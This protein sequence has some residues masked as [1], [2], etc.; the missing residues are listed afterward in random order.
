[1][2]PPSRRLPQLVGAFLALLGVILGAFAAHF[3][4]PQLLANGT[5]DAF[6]TGLYYQWFHA[7]ALLALGAAGAVRRGPIVCWTL[8][9][10][11][12]SG[13]LYLLSLDPSLH[14][15]GPV[16]PLG[17]LM[18]IVGWVWFIVQLLRQ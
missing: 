4:K 5:W 9:V 3:L 7:L 2:S 12:F 14:W 17:G 15:A 1:M 13:S 10:V 16:T 11:F 18:F 6:H 8:G